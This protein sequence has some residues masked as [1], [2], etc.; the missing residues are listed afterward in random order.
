MSSIDD[1]FNLPSVSDNPEFLEYCGSRASYLTTDEGKQNHAKLLACQS[2]TY[3][4][5][6]QSKTDKDEHSREGRAAASAKLAIQSAADTS[7]SGQ[8]EKPTEEDEEP[9]SPSAGDVQSHVS[10][11]TVDET[12]EK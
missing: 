2:S 12:V 3:E 6:L 10:K 4:E 11:A 8:E 9:T 7:T 5:F 1:I